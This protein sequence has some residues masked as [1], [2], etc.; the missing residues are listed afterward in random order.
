MDIN[1]DDTID[2][3]EFL[4]ATIHMSKLNREDAMM[5]AFK[6]FDKDESGMITKEELQ[7]AL[8]DMGE[9]SSDIS[10][11]MADADTNMDGKISYTEFCTMMRNNNKNSITVSAK[12]LKRGVMTVPDIEGLKEPED[13]NI[14]QS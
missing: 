12:A 2:Y 9:D 4:A 7:H 10:A 5:E 13:E 11:I 6:H 3:E 1:G 14:D 8:Q